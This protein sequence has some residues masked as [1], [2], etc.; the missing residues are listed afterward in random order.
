[1]K[2]LIFGLLL[3]TGTVHLTFAQSSRQRWV[4]SVYNQ[5]SEKEK[6][7]QLFMVA[8][9]SG[10]EKYN[11][12]QIQALIDNRLVGGLI[13]MQGTAEAQANQTNIFQRSSKVPL[14]IGMDA[15]WG[16]GMR[17]TGVQNFPRQMML[18]ATRN[19]SLME[20]MATAI[21]YQCKRLGVHIDFA[22]DI[23]VNNNPDNP[24]INFRSF[25]DNKEWVS[26]MGSAFT[27]GL[28]DNG[29]MACVKHF[30]GHG[31]VSVDS[32]LDLPVI[33]KTK[34][35][36]NDLELYPFRKL[37]Q[38]KVQS[39]MI[40][41]LSLPAYESRKDV[42][43]TL[44][45]PIVTDLLQNEMGFKGLIFTDALNMKGVTKFYPNGEA[46]LQAFLAGNDV[47]LFSEDV[48][49]A[50]AKIQDAIKHKK[51]T[52]ARL[53]KSVRKILNAKYD[54]GLHTY[55]TIP[56]ANATVDLNRYTQAIFEQVAAAAIT[57]VKD[58]NHILDKLAM[59]PN[60][61][62]AYVSVGKDENTTATD[63]K[64]F[65]NMLK[66][67]LPNTTIFSFAKNQSAARMDV[68]VNNLKKY[69]AVIIG[70][71][72]L[73]LYPKDNYGIDAM[74]LAFLKQLT[75]SDK[76]IFLNFGN[77]YASKYIC[78]AGSSIIAY[79]ENYATY[80]AT[81]NV[82]L[83][84]MTAKGVLPVQPCPTAGTYNSSGATRNIP[85]TAVPTKTAVV[86]T[87][88][89]TQTTTNPVTIATNLIKNPAAIE[90]LD[91]Y[92]KGSIVKGVFPGCQVL[93][94]KDGQVVY[95]KNYGA[96][97][98]GSSTPIVDQT[99]FDVASV[100]KL[101]A[102]TLAV[103]KLY[104]Q[105]KINLNYT[106]GDYLPFV[107]GSNKASLKIS[108]ILLHQA[109][110]KAWIPF[111]KSTLDSTGPNPAIYAAFKSG[112]YTVP[113]ASGMFMNQNYTDTIWKTI[114]ESPVSY[115]AA[116]VYSDLDFIFLQKVVEAITKM[117]LD[118]YVE[119]TFYQPLG[120][121]N[122]LYNPWERNWQLRCAPT[123][124]DNYFRYQQLQGYVHDMAAA[125][126]GGTA[127]HA[128]LFSNAEDLGIIMQMLANGGTYRGKQMFSPQTVEYFT[129]YRSGTSRRGY[130]FDKP[131]KRA[132]DGGPASEYCSKSTFGHQGFTGT[133]VWADPKTGIV[134]VFLSNRINPT[135][136]N[137]LINKLSVRTVAQDYIYKALGY[138]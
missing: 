55:Q 124:R 92:L 83:G 132:G 58:N 39:V 21:A 65:Y 94:M 86:N 98:Y 66:A 81:L 28:Q 53:E 3:I 129:G 35:Q 71:Q 15:E 117:P 38:A 47:L 40:A 67:A 41:H 36:L 19:P 96:Y 115:P 7:G 37:F 44:S 118:E 68:L 69:D 2:K 110:L 61:S 45:Y 30:P 79:E 82:L 121:K 34:Q 32:H 84:R 95:K 78:G 108:N 22:P 46:D 127:G 113:V 97:S 105:G 24:V 77:A 85:S 104:E 74:Q 138:N 52:A 88:V 102:T 56:V 54:A 8:A 135:A 23:D 80:L 70:M 103:M 73:N 25:G 111:Y 87:P 106:L 42:P 51:I 60:A 76:T 119:K 128:G 18:G 90:A 48:P 14:L 137:N 12:G 5:L 99:L 27:K 75:L 112:R 116:Y 125:M 13:F 16:L 62:Y 57:L 133:C 63:S 50:I 10:G 20:Q 123:E 126:M 131:E 130:G 93:A 11:Q 120:L 109:G 64:A 49:K 31:D 91:S 6:I 136:D 114:L 1:M 59:R 107:K 33:S 29:V 122:T 4:D 134:F 43:S 26:I 89:T 17:L 9:Y 72:D 100:T 101:A